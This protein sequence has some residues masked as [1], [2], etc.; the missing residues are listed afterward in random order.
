M[1]FIEIP[2]SIN[3]ILPEILET[4]R[5]QIGIISNNMLLRNMHSIVEQEKNTR[6]SDINNAILGYIIHNTTTHLIYCFNNPVRQIDLL[7]ILVRLS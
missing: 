4:T 1:A 2:S 5:S 3:F 7:G 6:T